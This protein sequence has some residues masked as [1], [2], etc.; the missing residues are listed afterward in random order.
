[1]SEEEKNQIKGWFAAVDSDR[2]GQV[3]ADEL[4]RALAM[5]GL[6]VNP[7]ALGRLIGAFDADG[8]GTIGP[9]EF[10]AVHKFLEQM[11]GSFAF[12]DADRSGTLD[13]NELHQALTRSGYQIS[14]PSFYAFCPKFDTQK[15]GRV[16]FDQY[17]EMCIW[18]GNMQKLWQFY[19]PQ[20]RGSIQLTFDQLLATTPYFV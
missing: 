18:L 2:S 5:G 9:D 8:T 4:G 13:L 14:M 7:A 17:L 3:T 19:D 20:R 11:R 6:Q 10:V 15:I 1:M 16:T 12:F